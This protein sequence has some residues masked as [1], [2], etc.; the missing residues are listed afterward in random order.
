MVEFEVYKDGKNLSMLAPHAT[1]GQSKMVL[2]L[3]FHLLTGTNPTILLDAIQQA[4]ILCLFLFYM[5]CVV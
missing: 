3:F 5:L 1:F 4:L 2:F